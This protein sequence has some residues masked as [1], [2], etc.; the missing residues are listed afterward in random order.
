MTELYSSLVRSLLLRYLLDHPVHGKKRR[1]RVRSFD[2]LPQDVYEQLCEL[3][4]I[5]YEGIIHGPQVIFSDLPEDFE[6]LSLMQCTPELYVDEGATLSYNFLHLT[7]Q[8]YLAAFHLSQQPVEK[9][10]EQFR[11]YCSGKDKQSNTHIHMVLQFLSGMRKF[12]GYLSEL[13]NVLSVEVG[14]SVMESDSESGDD[15]DTA[16]REV[17]HEE[18]CT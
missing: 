1:W 13:L 12:S 4:K 17:T 11:K 5:A 2:D 9:Q 8:E 10:V 14:E 15:S 7:V 6:T 3:G 18:V 16:I